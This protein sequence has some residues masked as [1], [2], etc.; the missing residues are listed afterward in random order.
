M[1]V[2]S[3]CVRVSVCVTAITR[4]LPAGSLPEFPLASPSCD[5]LSAI[6]W[7]PLQSRIEVQLLSL[8]HLLLAMPIPLCTHPQSRSR[9]MLCSVSVEHRQASGWG[10][11]HT[12]QA[13]R[14]HLPKAPAQ[15]TPGLG[16][17]KALLESRQ[18]HLLGPRCHSQPAASWSGDLHIYSIRPARHFD[19]D[20]IK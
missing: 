7:W 5:S 16:R 18:G 19:E 14:P 10:W 2:R 4:L 15:Q 3:W 12:Q 9:G 17:Q 8:P 20:C 11:R 6:R 1:Q 13:G